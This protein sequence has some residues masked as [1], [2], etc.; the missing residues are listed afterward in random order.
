MGQGRCCCSSSGGP[1]AA[2]GP[3]VQLIDPESATADAPRPPESDRLSERSGKEVE[4]EK[5]GLLPAAAA[6]AAG[7][8]ADKSS[9][10]GPATGG[11]RPRPAS[12]SSTDEGS[13]GTSPSPKASPKPKASLTPKRADTGANPQPSPKVFNSSVFDTLNS[14]VSAFDSLES[15]YAEMTREER[16][17]TRQLVKDFVKKMVKGQDLEVVA[18]SGEV[19]SCFCALSR[20]LDKL[21]VSVGEKGQDKRVR[22]IPLSGVTEVF[23]GG[24]SGAVDEDLAVTLSL[25]TQECITLRVKDAESRDQLI[26]CLTMFSNQA[27]SSGK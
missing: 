6:S 26:Q 2:N 14:T 21:K 22:E 13:G 12:L 11:K 24:G 19:R 3:P 10:Q 25:A 16:Q 8:G 27:K 5:A 23:G 9:A 7:D 20:K 18:A 15:A 4:G 1:G 17:E